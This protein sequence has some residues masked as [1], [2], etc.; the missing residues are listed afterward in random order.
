MTFEE[1]ELKDAE[2]TKRLMG[3]VLGPRKCKKCVKKMCMWSKIPLSFLHEETLIFNRKDM[4][5][6]HK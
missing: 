2:R 5:D 4:E 3:M 1:W 6:T